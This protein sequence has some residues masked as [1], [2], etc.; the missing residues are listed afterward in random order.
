MFTIK[1]INDVGKYAQVLFLRMKKYFFFQIN[2]EY[3]IVN[4][5]SIAVSIH[6]GN[7]FYQILLD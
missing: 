1:I 7:I 2:T 4:M 5:V 6:I 3:G